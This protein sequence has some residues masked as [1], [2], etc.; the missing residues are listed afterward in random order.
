M[1]ALLWRHWTPLYSFPATFSA[2][3]TQGIGGTCSQLLWHARNLRLLGVDVEVLG[4]TRADHF[5]EGVDFIGSC[6]ADDQEGLIRSGRVAPPDMILLEGAY[7]AAPF[8]KRS[9]PSATI[10]HVGQNIDLHNSQQP[11]AQAASID[12]WA[13]VGP[14]QYAHFCVARP[15]LRDR[16]VMLRNV[17]P[18]EWIYSKITAPPPR[19]DSVIWV[20]GWSKLGL[21]SWAVTMERIMRE[22]PSVRWLLL[23]PQ[24]GS[25]VGLEVSGH[26]FHGLSF[27]PGTVESASVP[28]QTV[29]QRLAEA[30]V[31][32]TSLGDETACVSVLDGHA[33]GRP[34]VSGNDLVFKYGNPEGTGLRVFS[35]GERYLA[36]SKL[37]DSPTLCEKMGRMGRRLVKKSF[38]EEH[39]RGDMQDIVEL[40]GILPQL[41][42]HSRP[43]SKLSLALLRVG[44]KVQRKLLAKAN[45]S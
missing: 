5:E 24:Y 9:F 42:V 21:R 16:F 14:G 27:R 8:F 43:P 25:H 34:V 29:F 38:T 41:R 13:F 45:G 18:W 2:L 44:E 35:N 10:V 22:R 1:K 20:G 36:V 28:L 11:F 23:G 31:V 32:L 12:L 17:V 19:L 7:S 15:D 6:S 26:I 3:E 33:A 37:L 4:A 30:H 39:Q 40:A